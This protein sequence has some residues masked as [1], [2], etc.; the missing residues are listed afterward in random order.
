MFETLKTLWAQVVAV[1]A[2]PEF[3]PRRRKFIGGSVAGAASAAAQASGIAAEGMT[4]EAAVDL[5]H[6]LRQKM[7]AI[8]ETNLSIKNASKLLR[9]GE[10]NLFPTIIDGKAWDIG[11]IT[12]GIAGVNNFEEVPKKPIGERWDTMKQEYADSYRQNIN[13]LMSTIG[14]QSIKIPQSMLDWRVFGKMPVDE[15]GR[16]TVNRVVL[17]NAYPANIHDAVLNAM[18]EQAQKIWEEGANFTQ[19]FKTFSQKLLQGPLKRFS[20]QSV[21]SDI[22]LNTPG[23]SEKARKKIAEMNRDEG[24]FQREIEEVQHKRTAKNADK[25]EQDRQEAQ[26]NNKI[27]AQD[28]APILSAFLGNLEWHENGDCL[29]AYIPNNAGGR[30]AFLSMVDLLKEAG[31]RDNEL[32]TFEDTVF[33]RDTEGKAANYPDDVRV[34][35]YKVLSLQKQHV[36][37]LARLIIGIGDGEL[38]L[39]PENVESTLFRRASQLKEMRELGVVNRKTDASTQ[40]H[41]GLA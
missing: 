26:E 20:P 8:G 24:M 7:G 22:S 32:P 5:V 12:C 31:A 17:S 30:R 11:E 6:A 13:D 37:V 3:D 19:T 35:T 10:K 4:A 25:A 29:E 33:R 9:N 18:P 14:D 15:E 21:Y 41:L 2:V 34:P 23:G 28:F 39:H 36:P 16:V 27:V 40:D 1:V 38:H